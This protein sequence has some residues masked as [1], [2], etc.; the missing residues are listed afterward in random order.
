MAVVF[1]VLIFAAIA[2]LLV[3]A[4]LM[5][6]ARPKSDTNTAP[7]PHDT[8]GASRTPSGSAARKERKRRRNQSKNA[9]RKRH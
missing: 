9:R 4:V 3:A 2:V 5:R 6:N 7:V 1:Y 8:S